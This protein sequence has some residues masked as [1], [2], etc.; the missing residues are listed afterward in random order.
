M[1]RQNQA[2]GLPGPEPKD[3]LTPTHAASSPSQ[4]TSTKTIAAATF[5]SPFGSEIGSGLTLEQ[6]TLSE[7]PNVVFSALHFVVRDVLVPIAAYL[8]DSCRA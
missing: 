6:W 1:N 4:T 3:A 7:N 5:Q 8:L 2:D